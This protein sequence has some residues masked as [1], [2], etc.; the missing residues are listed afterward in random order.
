MDELAAPDVDPH[1]TEAAEEDEI[2]RLQ[3]ALG[4]R[5]AIAV[6]RRGVVGQRDAD[7]VERVLDEA[8]AIKPARGRTALDIRSAEVPESY[9]DDAAVL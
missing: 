9:P 7:L 6:L 1:V 3:V 4:N 8:G 2:A 5:R